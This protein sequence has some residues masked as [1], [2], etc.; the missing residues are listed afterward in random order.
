MIEP[1]TV[2]RWRAPRKGGAR[3]AREHT[4][5][6]QTASSRVARGAGR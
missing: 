4:P 2:A 5:G 6:R 1:S 3:G